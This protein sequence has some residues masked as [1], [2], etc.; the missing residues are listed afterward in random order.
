MICIC[1][2]A[3]SKKVV[4]RNREGGLKQ[5]LQLNTELGIWVLYFYLWTLS[6]LANE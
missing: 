5:K 2:S 4:A 3:L 1:F 6:A